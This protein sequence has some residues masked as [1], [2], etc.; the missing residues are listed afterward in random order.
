[1]VQKFFLII[2]KLAIIL[3]TTENG[4]NICYSL[5]K[6]LKLFQ[7]FTASHRTWNISRV[8]KGNRLIRLYYEV[9]LFYSNLTLTMITNFKKWFFINLRFQLILMSIIE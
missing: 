6:S 1:M 7:S 4:V 2:I 5:L 9:K 3:S 8:D